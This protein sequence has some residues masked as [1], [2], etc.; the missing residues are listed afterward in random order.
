MARN[1]RVIKRRYWGLFQI[2]IELGLQEVY[3]QS[4]LQNSTMPA[5]PH[6]SKK[7]LEELAR[8]CNKLAAELTADLRHAVNEIE[9]LKKELHKIRHSSP[10]V[11]K[12]SKRNRKSTPRARAT[13]TV[14]SNKSGNN[15][16]RSPPVPHEASHISAS[17]VFPKEPLNPPTP[18]PEPTTGPENN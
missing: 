6:R 8:V 14:R 17:F 2:N 12:N 9:N 3:N 13:T 10:T 4:I 18:P 15:K 5:V 7:A 11:A 16:R 1:S